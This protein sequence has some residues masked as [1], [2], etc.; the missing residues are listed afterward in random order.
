MSDIT[1]DARDEFEKI[2]PIPKHVIRCGKGYAC[3]EYNAWC[4]HEFINKWE[5]WSAA[6]HNHSGDTTEKASPA[7]PAGWKLG[8]IEPTADMSHAGHDY[9]QKSKAEFGDFTP[10]GMYRSMFAAAPQPPVSAS[11]WIK[12]SDKK[13]A[14][15]DYISAV[16]HHGE[17]VS[18]LVNG[19]WID[20]HDGSTFAIADIYLW[21]L[22]PEIPA[23]P[24]P[25]V[26][27][28]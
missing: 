14:Q 1:I 24:K 16:S 10:T 27:N 20:L 13:P 15:Q 11:G 2:F 18:G 28:D 25:E 22:L 23:A 5:G 6:M 7:I 8:P 9:Y 12:C 19:E 3:T 4:G 21:L 26:N 17:Y